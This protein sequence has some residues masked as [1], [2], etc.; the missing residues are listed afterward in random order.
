MSADYSNRISRN[1][2][3]GKSTD[4]HRAPT[5]KSEVA[6]SASAHEWTSAISPPLPNKCP[7]HPTFRGS[8]PSKF[9][10]DITLLLPRNSRVGRKSWVH[11]ERPAHSVGT[12]VGYP[13]PQRLGAPAPE[14]PSAL[15]RCPFLRLQR[16]PRNIPEY[17]EL[18]AVLEQR[19]QFDRGLAQQGPVGAGDIVGF[20][21]QRVGHAQ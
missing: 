13:V 15:L 18:L 14:R 8:T 7:D 5:H 3:C 1:L 6:H 2:S 19:P 20:P 4:P 12:R 10:L 9:Q 21:G 16:Q 17:Q 11:E